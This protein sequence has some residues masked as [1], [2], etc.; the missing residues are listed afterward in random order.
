MGYNMGL[1]RFEQET[2]INFNKLDDFADVFT[3][4][5]TWQRHIE[6]KLG[7]KPYADNGNGGKSY[8]VPK[9]RISKPRAPR[10]MTDESRRKGAEY[11]AKARKAKGH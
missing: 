9:S 11:L 7:I 2:I 1:S 8:K 4:E 6:N 3:Y 5:F 10:T